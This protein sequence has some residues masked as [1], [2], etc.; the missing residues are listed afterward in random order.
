MLKI[1]LRLIFII[2]VTTYFHILTTLEF[3]R[4]TISCLSFKF[5]SPNQ[6]VTIL[7]HKNNVQH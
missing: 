1:G 2:G 7:T 3:Q 4:L 5:I 6:K